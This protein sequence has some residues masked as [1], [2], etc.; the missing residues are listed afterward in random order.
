V[1]VLFSGMDI[2]GELIDGGPRFRTDWTLMT[3]IEW[4]AGAYQYSSMTTQLFWVPNHALAGWLF[5]GLLFR[6]EKTSLLDASWPILLVAAAIWSPLTAVG[7]VPFVVA[8]GVALMRGT[9]L[10]GMLDARGL[11]PALLVGIAIAGYLTLDPGGVRRGVTLGAAGD[12]A[13]SVL[14]QVQ[15][16]LLEAGLLGIAILLL[17]PSAELVVALAVLLLLPSFSF[18]PG[19][20]LVMR[21]SIP[22]LVVLMISALRALLDDRTDRRARRARVGRYPPHYVA[23]LADRPLA[24][25][26]RPPHALDPG[27][28]GPAECDNPGFDLMW[29]HLI[30]HR[31]ASHAD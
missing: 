5:M 12:T 18:G 19:N 30:P 9:G 6:H 1:L 7:L 17:R 2:V 3:H 16:F 8:R 29:A 31:V 28:Q 27:P 11:I 22:S 23:H 10:R 26:L 13:M 4:W 24:H 15:F 14:R 21:A 25:I 20:D